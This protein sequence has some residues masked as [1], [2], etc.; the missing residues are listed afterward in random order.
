MQPNPLFTQE[1]RLQ[2]YPI[3]YL[4]LTYTLILHPNPVDPNP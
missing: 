2:S 4:N 3:P 1:L